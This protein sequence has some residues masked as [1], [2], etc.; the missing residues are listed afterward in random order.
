[1]MHGN[2]HLDLLRRTSYA[3]ETPGVPFTFMIEVEDNG[4]IKK[5][6]RTATGP[7][8]KLYPLGGDLDRSGRQVGMPTILSA[9]AGRAQVER[10][11][12]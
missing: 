3:A 7:G 11:F 2:S 5:A 10:V 1:M 8:L 12:A 6:T 9:L 4:S